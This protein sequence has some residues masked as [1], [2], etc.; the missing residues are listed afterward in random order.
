MNRLSILAIF[1]LAL[2]GCSNREPKAPKPDGFQEITFD[3]SDSRKVYAD[4]YPS[5]TLNSEKVILMFHQADSN[6]GEYESIEPVV[7][8]MGYNC[9][10]VDQRSGGNMWERDNRT[11]TKS[12]AGDYTSAYND[13][14]GAID[15]A[16]SKNYTTI[17]VWGSSYSASLAFRLASEDSSVKA[18]IAFSP[19][20][21][22]DDKTEVKGWASKVS[23][24]TFFACKPDELSDGRQELFDAIRSDTKVLASF[25]GG[26]HGSST[27]LPEKSLAAKQYM[28]KLKEFLT[29]LK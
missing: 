7:A 1:A 20:E 13:M 11:A 28:D 10:A 22:M 18:V 17:I 14:L 16:H 25:P 26:S 23:V 15:Y 12:G 24:P 9:I 8:A 19:G 4:F 27:L 21:Y 29:S 5:S 3:A 2:V 6:A